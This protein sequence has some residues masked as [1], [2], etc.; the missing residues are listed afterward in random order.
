VSTQRLKLHR[1]DLKQEI[2]TELDD[3]VAVDKAVCIIVNDEYY[4]T[5]IATPTMVKELVIGHLVG[6]GIVR[7]LDDVKKVEVSPLKVYVELY[8]D[9]DL[10]LINMSKVNLITTACGTTGAPLR[11]G[12]LK[13]LKVLGDIRIE[14]V[15]V[16]SMV[17]ELNKRS[18]MFRRTGGTHSAMLCSIDG[19]V[20]VFAEDVGR[21]NAID[22]VVG[23]AILSGVD[24]W[25]C[26]LVSS[27]RQS[28]EI[29]LKAAR[30]G[31]PLIASVAGPLASGIKIADAA[32]TTLICFV[33]GRRMN[34]YTHPER[35]ILGD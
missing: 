13:P 7:T 31:I 11:N 8:G 24:L 18:E 29:V 6:E 35:I 16:L 27:G 12:Q 5:L 22:K 19:E 32:G 21:H 33:R 28:G 15:K 25:G 14:A 17:R 10:N 2:I 9:V 1:F 3:V 4:R 20:V 34:V 30:S 26:V 23:A